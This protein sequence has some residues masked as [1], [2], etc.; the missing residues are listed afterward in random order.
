MT[1]QSP[2]STVSTVSS[3]PPKNPKISD[4]FIDNVRNRIEYHRALLKKRTIYLGDVE[5]RN[6]LTWYK[7]DVGDIVIEKQI[8]SD[9]T[10]GKSA[11]KSSGKAVD[12]PNDKSTDS[13]IDTDYVPVP[14]RLS[15][16][17][18]LT[19]RDFFLSSDGNWTGPNIAAEKLE[20]V[21]ISCTA[22]ASDRDGLSREFNHGLDTIDGLILRASN[23]Q[24]ARQS[25]RS[26]SEIDNKQKIKFRHALFGV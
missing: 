17:A 12:R 23:A 19:H 4:Y 24:F 5:S 3:T 21:K 9:T 15:L 10:A 26:R 6:R 13:T 22:G 18:I 20:D 1:A 14:A 11:D 8:P 7:S 16:I 25:L 2:A